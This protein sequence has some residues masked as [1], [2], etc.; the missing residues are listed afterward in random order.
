[1][2]RNGRR[3]GCLDSDLQGLRDIGANERDGAGVVEDLDK[4]AVDFG[5]AA[6]PAC[7]ACECETVSDRDAHDETKV[8]HP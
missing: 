6:N 4:D 7:I 2:T 1:M 5:D 8:E 3:C